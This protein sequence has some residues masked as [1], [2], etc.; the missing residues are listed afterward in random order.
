MEQYQPSLEKI[1][2]ANRSHGTGEAL[3]LA[4]CCICS[5]FT[6]FIAGLMIMF[7]DQFNVFP[8]NWKKRAPRA[9]L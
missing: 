8:W 1:C 9:I 5:F 7:G 4:S 6:T 2:Q 3:F